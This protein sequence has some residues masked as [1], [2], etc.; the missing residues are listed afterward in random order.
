MNNILSRLS[1]NFIEFINGHSFYLH[2][3][4]HI[5]IKTISIIAPLYLHYIP[6]VPPF[7]LAK[8]ITNAAAVTVVS[9]FCGSSR[10]PTASAPP[11]LDVAN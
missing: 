6:I 7:L 11:E 9:L 1:I 4:K 10:C 8:S 3:I 5:S 2:S